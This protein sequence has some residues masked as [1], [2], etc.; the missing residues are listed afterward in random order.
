MEQVYCDRCGATWSSPS[1]LAPAIG[2]EVAMLI[3]RGDAIS[4]IRR[5]RESA[6]L[7]LR[8]AKAVELHI[9]REPGKCQR[10]GAAL[11]SSGV[12]ACSRCRSLNYDW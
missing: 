4:A 8:D 12:V 3:R 9:T 5:L 10:C 7:G 11:E 1:A 2:Q 6:G